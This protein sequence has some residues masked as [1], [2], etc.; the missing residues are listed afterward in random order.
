[1]K[2]I[3]LSLLLCSS[4]VCFAQNWQPFPLGQKSYF[5]HNNVAGYGNSTDTLLN[6]FYVDSLRDYGTS[7]TLYFNF[8]TPNI[9]NCYS[10]IISSG[11]YPNYF[12]YSIH[13]N[14]R[15]DSITVTN[16]E[17]TFYSYDYQLN[18]QNNFVFKPLTQK[19]SSWT[20][21]ST[22][23][24]FNQ[25]KITCDSIYYDVIL[26]ATSDSVKLFSVQALN[27]GVPVYDVI[28]QDKYLISKNY[29][30]KKFKNFPLKGI[31]TSLVQEGFNPPV[32]EDYFHLNIG[33]V[34][35]WEEKF[36]TYPGPGAPPSYIKYY[37]DSI[38]GVYYSSDTISY[39]IF[40]TRNNLTTYNTGST[41]YK[42]VDE[43]VFSASTSTLAPKKLMTQG[44]GNVDLDEVSPYYIRDGIVYKDKMNELKYLDTN[45]GNCS[46]T[47]MMD[48]G[49]WERYNTKYGVYAYGNTSINEKTYWNIIGSTIN[50]VQE[51]SSWMVIT[52]DYQ[53]NKQNSQPFSI[54][55]NPSK[56]GNF[57]L[58]SEHTK[59]LEIV[60]IDGQIVFSQSLNLPKTEIKTN[61]PKGLYFVKLRFEN[62]Q[63][64]IQKL[65]VTD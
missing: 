14:E 28:N 60:S 7:Q 29:G 11:G 46:P 3:I 44:F 10:T 65:I 39:G 30:F 64:V 26:G 22:G 15:P 63:E 2:K 37:K 5:V 27:N 48:Y 56:S 18:P 52:A 23:S 31:K 24:G 49:W 40:R 19:D 9:G 17:Y 47:T 38:V 34:L 33:D 59:R 20:F 54:Y 55:P 13:D 62:R 4:L 25:L 41:R 1:M 57:V 51:G 53:I 61:L 43:V 6:E 16:N 58:E 42:I 32:F 45:S 50:G 8:T 36:N 21:A 12:Y 35:I